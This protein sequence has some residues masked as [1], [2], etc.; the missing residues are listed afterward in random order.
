[1][2]TV[3][4]ARKEYKELIDTRLRYEYLRQ[5]MTDD[6]FAPPSSRNKKEIVTEK[7]V[8]RWSQEARALHKKG[9]L[10]FFE[11]LIEKEY[12]EIAKKFRLQTR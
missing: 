12:P 1:M 4:I 8:L 9:K 3:T 7:D 11:K 5:I 10:L 6:V 2:N